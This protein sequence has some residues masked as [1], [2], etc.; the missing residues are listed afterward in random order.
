[1]PNVPMWS[2]R[3]QAHGGR[4]RLRILQ[5]IL[6]ILGGRPR[7]RRGVPAELDAAVPP[8][9]RAQPHARRIVGTPAQVADLLEQWFAAGARRRLPSIC[10]ATLLPDGLERA[11]PAGWCPSSSGAASSA[12]P[13]PGAYACVST[14]WT[15]PS[16]RQG[17]RYDRSPLGSCR[18]AMT[19]QAPEENI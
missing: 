5:S 6:P 1:M 10:P 7:R 15:L 4:A 2:A 11:D 14:C 9:A 16:P 13:T 12:A 17:L 18:T 19:T 8:G 3:P